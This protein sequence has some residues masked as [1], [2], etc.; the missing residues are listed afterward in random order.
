MSLCVTYNPPYCWE[1]NK[2]W[3]I[4]PPLWFP[5]RPLAS[6]LGT[7][8]LRWFPGYRIETLVTERGGREIGKFLNG[9]TSW[10]I[11]ADVSDDLIQ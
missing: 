6:C 1:G 11:R 2:G 10:E 9:L 4:A 7:L 5:F 8:L 3:S